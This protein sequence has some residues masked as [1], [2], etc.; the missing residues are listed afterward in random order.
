MKFI[1]SNEI[2]YL[3]NLLKNYDELEDVCKCKF[4]K[5]LKIIDCSKEYT[6]EEKNNEYIYI[7]GTHIKKFDFDFCSEI[8]KVFIDNSVKLIDG[9]IFSYCKSLTSIT[10][11]NSLKSIGK[12]AFS[13]CTSLTSIKIPNGIESI[14]ASAFYYCKSLTS[15]TLPNSL[16]SIGESAFSHCTYLTSIKIPNSVNQ[17]VQVHFIIVN[18]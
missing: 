2:G 7:K 14:G 1:K 16:K 5:E 17:L 10:L 8:K 15:I 9:Y 4:G 3:L 13:H 18:H 11:P 6:N 12:G